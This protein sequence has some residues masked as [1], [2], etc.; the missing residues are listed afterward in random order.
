MICP[1]PMQHHDQRQW[2]P[3]GV[4]RGIGDGVPH[5]LVASVGV[6]RARHHRSKRGKGQRGDRYLAVAEEGDQRLVTR[7]D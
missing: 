7:K 1:E 5:G 4:V 2:S 3:D 6:E